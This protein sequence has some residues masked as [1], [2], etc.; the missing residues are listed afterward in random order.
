MSKAK[1]NTFL[2]G[3]FS[4]LAVATAGLGYLAWSSSE[5]SSQAGE[6]YQA[7]KAKLQ[8]LHKAP[9]FPNSENVDA[10]KKQVSAFTEKVKALSDTLRSNQAP[11]DT[12]MNNSKFQDKLQKTRDAILLEAKNADVKLPETFDL[13]MGTYL[14]AFPE[15]SAV[16]KLNAWLDG[17]EFFMSSL[18]KNGVKEVSA[19]TR[20]EMAFEKKTDAK[21]A[22]AA[23]AG[24]AKAPAKPV[25]AAKGKEKDKKAEAAPVAAIEEKAALERYPFNVTFTTSNRSLNQIMTALAAKGNFLYNIRVLRIENDQKN[26]AETAT[27]VNVKEEMDKVTNRP[28][29]RDSIF[30]FGEEKLQVHLGI[31]LIRFEEPVVAEIKK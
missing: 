13:G 26:G 27:P 4:V 8:A 11:L 6:T 30:I 10:K 31:D 17:I 16:P 25:A 18:I 22:E 29:K 24:K 3:Y 20:P 7:A 1:Q 28:F 14:A 21:P 19:F 9:I 12:G 2:I 15:T 23:T 5:A